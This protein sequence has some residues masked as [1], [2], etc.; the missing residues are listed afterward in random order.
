MF[1]VIFEWLHIINS[2]TL[3][4]LLTTDKVMYVIDFM[5]MEPAGVCGVGDG[6]CRY[7]W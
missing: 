2:I 4:F 3:D 7:F 5:M 1:S 6:A